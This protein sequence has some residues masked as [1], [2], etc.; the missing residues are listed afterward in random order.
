[1]MSPT[2]V[3]ALGRGYLDKLPFGNPQPHKFAG[4]HV[5]TDI[6]GDIK[7][8]AAGAI[9]ACIFAGIIAF[10]AGRI[11]DNR[12]AGNSGALMIIAGLGAAVLY[13]IAYPLT[14]GFTSA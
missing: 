3:M 8:I 2:Q 14:N 13:G 6:I 9:L 7:Y 11:I 10:T 5:I 4:M 12:R 1:M